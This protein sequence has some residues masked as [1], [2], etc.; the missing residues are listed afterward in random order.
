MSRSEP[1]KQQENRETNPSQAHLAQSQR[2]ILG[3]LI[4]NSQ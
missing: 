1:L 2:D 4:E 3:N